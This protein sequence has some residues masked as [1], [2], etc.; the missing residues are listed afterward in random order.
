MN[1]NILEMVK[2]IIPDAPTNLI[3]YYIKK[4]INY[5]LIITNQKTVPSNA[6]F[7]IVD[8]VII[9]YNKFGYE[10]LT[11]TNQNSI[12]LNFGTDLPADIRRAMI[13]FTCIRW[14]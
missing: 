4:A 14:V 5:F 1:E 12:S 2:S 9:Y 8:L 11:S 7:I 6:E 13:K 10:G 3:N